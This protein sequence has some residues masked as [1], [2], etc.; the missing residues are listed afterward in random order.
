[1][2][3]HECELVGG[4]V[5]PGDRRDERQRGERHGHLEET[6]TGRAATPVEHGEEHTADHGAHE[7]ELGEVD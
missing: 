1:V 2:Q 7:G 6:A 5:G 3:R 4:G